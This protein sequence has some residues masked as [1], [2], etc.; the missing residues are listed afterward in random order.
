[1]EITAF[2]GQSA[3][4]KQEEEEGEEGG[5]KEREGVEGGDLTKH[6]HWSKNS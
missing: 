3:R 1:M 6:T 4:E 2:Q 5:R